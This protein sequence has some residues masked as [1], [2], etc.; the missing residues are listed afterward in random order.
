MVV[1]STGEHGM[2]PD[3]VEAMAFAWLAREFLARRPG[4]L[5]SV[6]GAEGPRRLGALYPGANPD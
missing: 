5:A 6:T 1:E 4:N 3:F 2:D